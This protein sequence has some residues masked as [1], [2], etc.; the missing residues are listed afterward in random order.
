MAGKSDG[1]YL[2][3]ISTPSNPI[4]VNACNTPGDAQGVHGIPGR[5]Y[6]FV[7]DLNEGL[8][9]IDMPYAGVK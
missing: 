8:Q 1:L 4:F 9:V 7:A 5:D 6:V 3:D 2:I